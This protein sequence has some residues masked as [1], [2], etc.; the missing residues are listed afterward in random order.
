[1]TH[2]SCTVF[3]PGFSQVWGEGREFG[4]VLDSDSL[5]LPNSCLQNLTSLPEFSPPLS[6]AYVN[7][8]PVP[9]SLGHQ[10]PLWGWQWCYNSPRS[11][12]G[13]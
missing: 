8:R 13:M 2:A 5:Y 12:G 3:F 6:K 11:C 9:F 4:V 1:M 7:P 10:I